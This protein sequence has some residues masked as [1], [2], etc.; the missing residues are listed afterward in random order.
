M[1]KYLVVLGLL[2]LSVSLSGQDG[3]E[4]EAVVSVVKQLFAG[5]RAGDSS[6]VSAI[7]HPTL[8]FQSAGM[9]QEGNPRLTESDPQSFLRAVGSAAPNVL[10]EQIWNY[11]VQ[12]DANLATVW[13]E[14]TF[15]RGDQLSHC[16]YNA[17]Q[18]F[19]TADGW[20]ITQII[21]SRRRE[22][23]TATSQDLQG[24]LHTLI[25]GWHKAAASADADAFFGKMTEDAVYIGTDATERWLRDELREWAKAAFERESAWTF[26]ATQRHISIAD[27]QRTAWWDEL[28]DTWMGPCRA[29]GVLENTEAGWRIKHY[30]LSVTVPNDKIESFIELVK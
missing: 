2:I 18:L 27:D 25:D 24:A 5:M 9:D 1:R 28:L 11:D 3:S 19:R 6:M 14:Y 12:I 23:C 30:Q 16:G 22:G 26:K 7:F 29:T 15:F 4:R 8:R 17:F 13:T 20:K 10:N 21:D